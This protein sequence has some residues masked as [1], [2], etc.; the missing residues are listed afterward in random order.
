MCIRL[1]AGARVP[2][3]SWPLIAEYALLKLP[4]GPSAGLLTLVSTEK[5]GMPR[6]VEAEGGAKGRTCSGRGGSPG[7]E[8]GGAA[9]P[10]STFHS[11]RKTCMAQEVGAL[12]RGP[13]AQ[14]YMGGWSPW[15]QV[16]GPPGETAPS[17]YT[18][19]GS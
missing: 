19:T 17:E 14:A 3:E 16:T 7:V 4:A 12:A 1:P 2:I 15:H 9:P 18:G 5:P 13:L 8:T 6:G 11:T 10:L